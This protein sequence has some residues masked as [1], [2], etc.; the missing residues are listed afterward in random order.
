MASTGLPSYFLVED[1]LGELGA[2]TGVT[3]AHGCLCGLACVLGGRAGAAWVA[4]LLAGDTAGEAGAGTADL[5]GELAEASCTALAEGAMAFMPLLP[6]DERPLAERT[7]ALGAW[8]TGFMEGL[9]EAA[10]SPGARAALASDTA[11]EIIGDFAEIAR[12]TVSQAETEPEGEAAYAEL[13]EFVRVSVQLMFEEL[14]DARD[15]AGST[16]LH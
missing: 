10:S 16:S 9:G 8:C 1:A 15:A 6:P 11:R 5:L 13:V 12:A 7:E 4:S 3:E 14:H 2:S